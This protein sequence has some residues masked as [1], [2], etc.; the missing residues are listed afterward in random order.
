MLGA[1]VSNVFITAG[2]SLQLGFIITALLVF[3]PSFWGAT[4][5]PRDEPAE[6]NAQVA[7]PKFN[8]WR[9][10]RTLKIAFIGLT[11]IIAEVSAATW[12]PIAL[13]QSGISASDAAVALSG[14]W[15]VLTIA[16][17]IGGALVDRVG[18][19]KTLLIAS[20]TTAAG[21]AL[22]GLTPFIHVPYLALLPWSAGM[23]LGFPMAI[24]AMADDPVRA[25]KRINMIITVV[26]L[27]GMIV[28]PLLG[29][30][31]QI[32]GIF[33]AF[34]IPTALLLIG[35]ALSNQARRL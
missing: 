13:V 22:F 24:N 4:V 12:V 9:E 7:A 19:A 23:A 28:G 15:L 29:S 16:R 27:S 17:A 21:V 8:P 5:F 33:I 31:G 14:F 20:L 2:V 6:A 34:V 1:L 25:A 26:Y 11:F 18:R 3:I 30:V 32:V 35:A 10:P